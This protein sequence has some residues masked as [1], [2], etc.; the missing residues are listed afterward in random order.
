[1]KKNKTTE[2]SQ[3]L[4]EVIKRKWIEWMKNKNLDE[5]ILDIE[6]YLI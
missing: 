6:K 4:I 3:F 1:M 2:Y 5:A